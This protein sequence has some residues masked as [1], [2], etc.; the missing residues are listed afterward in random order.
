[1]SFLLWRGLI[2]SKGAREPQSI[3]PEGRGGGGGLIAIETIG[4]AIVVHAVEAD[5][6]F[7]R[8]RAGQ[9]PPPRLPT[10]TPPPP[11]PPDPA[12]A[13][14]LTHRFHDY[15]PGPAEGEMVRGGGKYFEC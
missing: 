12:P 9:T 13:L 2:Y 10:P 4:I 6:F 11:T 7:T 15:R 5:V 14:Q 8:A 1:M 3:T